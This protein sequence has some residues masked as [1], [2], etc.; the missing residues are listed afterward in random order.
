MLYCAGTPAVD[1]PVALS[2]LRAEPEA[3]KSRAVHTNESQPLSKTWELGFYE[4]QR[5][6]QEAITD[7]LEIAVS[8]S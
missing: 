3:A 2:E 4:S 1:P 7:G 6:P 5:T 8:P